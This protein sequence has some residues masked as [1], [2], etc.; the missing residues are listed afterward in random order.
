MNSQIKLQSDDLLRI[1][2]CDGVESNQGVKAS[3]V[4]VVPLPIGHRNVA[5][6]VSE[7]RQSAAIDAVVLQKEL[8]AME[9][10][11]RIMSSPQS[12]RARRRGRR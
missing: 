5:D 11:R 8:E 2:S 9:C 4:V 3:Q 7:W 10:M 6:G 12:C 1:R